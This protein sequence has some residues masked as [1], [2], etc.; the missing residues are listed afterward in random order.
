MVIT[1]GLQRH[2]RLE[3]FRFDATDFSEERKGCVYLGEVISIKTQAEFET[4]E[5]RVREPKETAYRTIILMLDTRLVR[6]RADTVE[7]VRQRRPGSM[8]TLLQPKRTKRIAA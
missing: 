3:W 6:V 4:D 5:A 1:S 2:R 8:S 7:E